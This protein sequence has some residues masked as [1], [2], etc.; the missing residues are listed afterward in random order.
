MGG[1]KAVQKKS[2]MWVAGCILVIGGSPSV[3]RLRH[4][5]MPSIG[6]LQNYCCSHDPSKD[7]LAGSVKAGLKHKPY[8]AVYLEHFINS[9]ERIL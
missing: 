4:A 8:S 6:R 5:T 1:G 7:T 3:L 9:E 2:V